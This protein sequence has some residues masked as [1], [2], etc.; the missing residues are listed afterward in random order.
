MNDLVNNH[1]FAT[2]WTDSC[3]R[4]HWII[5]S[6]CLFQPEI[7]T[8]GKNQAKP[9]IIIFFTCFNFSQL[10]L[11]ALATHHSVI[12]ELNLFTGLIQ[13]GYSKQTFLKIGLEKLQKCF[14]TMQGLEIFQELSWL[15]CSRDGV[16]DLKMCETFNNLLSK[17]NCYLFDRVQ[18]TAASSPV[19]HKSL[20]SA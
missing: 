14:P 5:G 3:H 9:W 8:L 2:Y 7:N 1:L 4:F 15:T 10:K 13:R 12:D 18:E 16:S 6:F 20:W 19:E 17:K 11:H